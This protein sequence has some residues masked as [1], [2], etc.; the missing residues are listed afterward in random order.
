[1]LTGESVYAKK[2]LTLLLGEILHEGMHTA[3]VWASR[4][5]RVLAGRLPLTGQAGSLEAHMLQTMQAVS[6]TSFC[7]PGCLILPAP[8]PKAGGDIGPSF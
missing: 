7:L 1:M 8:I 4:L 6:C 5:L 2:P 3:E